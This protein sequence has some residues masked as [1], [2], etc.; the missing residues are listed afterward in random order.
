M[1]S[2]QPIYVTAIFSFPL[3]IIFQCLKK[4][5]TLTNGGQYVNKENNFKINLG[6]FPTTC[7]EPLAM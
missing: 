5:G 7:M 1:I 2:K 4:Y 6:V 3:M